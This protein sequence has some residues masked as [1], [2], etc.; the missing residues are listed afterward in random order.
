MLPERK[1]VRAPRSA[2]LAATTEVYPV[3]TID[4]SKVMG[5]RGEGRGWRV[6]IEMMGIVSWEGGV[7]VLVLAL[8]RF[9]TSCR[10]ILIQVRLILMIVN[11]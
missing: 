7:V 4:F 10:H 2:S 1:R 3:Q 5:R 6:E 9:R 11:H 8:G